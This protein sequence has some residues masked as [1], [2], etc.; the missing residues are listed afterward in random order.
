M[1][2]WHGLLL[3]PA[4]AQVLDHIVQSPRNGYLFIGK[5]G[6]GKGLVIREM[7]KQLLGINAE[8]D[9]DSHPDIIYLNRDEGSKDIKVKQ[10]RDL[11][12]RLSLTSARGGYQIVI[13]E[14]LDHLNEEAAN[15]LLKFI[16]EPPKGVIFFCTTDREERVLSTIRSRLTPLHFLPLSTVE[17]TTFLIGRGIDREVAG[18]AATQAHG[19]VGRALDLSETLAQATREQQEFVRVMRIFIDGDSGRV[20]SELERIAKRCQ[21]A[22]EPEHEWERVLEGLQRACSSVMKE[23]PFKTKRIAQGLA[24]SWRL[25]GT[26]I[27]PHLALEWAAISTYPNGQQAHPRFITNH[28][29]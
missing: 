18:Q 26:A 15:S 24:W 1:N 17:I 16:E 20:I 2:R 7:A 8:H 25:L 21:Q 22:E 27:S 29:V 6:C 11:I 23:H 28:F 3:Q 12:A 5:K 9:L 19:S 10:A 4:L 13:I 14:E